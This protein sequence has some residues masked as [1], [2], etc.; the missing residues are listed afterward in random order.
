MICFRMSGDDDNDDDSEYSNEGGPD[1]EMGV[2]IERAGC[3]EDT[4]LIEY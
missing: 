3:M 1:E 2:A 4:S